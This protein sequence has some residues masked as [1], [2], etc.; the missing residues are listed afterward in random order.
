MTVFKPPYTYRVSEHGPATIYDAVA[1]GWVARVKESL[2][3]KAELARVMTDALNR[4][5]AEEQATGGT[6]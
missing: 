6:P 3:H 1:V 4:A 5:A 2:P